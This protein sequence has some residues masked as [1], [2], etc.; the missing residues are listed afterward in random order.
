MLA[1]A[2]QSTLTDRIADRLDGGAR[3]R[4]LEIGCGEGRL[5][6]DVLARFGDRV[7]LHG[8]NAVRWAVITGE[9]GL[10][11]TND[12]YAVI[13]ADTFRRGPSPTIHLAD[14]QDLSKFPVADFDLIVSQVVLAHVA[15]KDRVLQ[16]SARLLAGG[17]EFVH[18][19][20]HVDR[21]APAFMD[22]DLPRFVIHRHDERVST[23][24]HLESKN[25]TVLTTRRLEHEAV[26]AS[27]HK[28]DRLDLGLRLD[29]QSTMGLTK[30]TTTDGRPLWGIRSMYHLDDP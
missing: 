26:V 29:E 12:R 13:P 20:D 19:L 5:L 16:E 8:I 2:A 3:V 14:A 18:E 21:A 6:L 10:R 24:A 4:M 15:H 25:I 23:R 1:A 9:R 28:S 7:E 17:G 30:I 22:D 11:A 27:F